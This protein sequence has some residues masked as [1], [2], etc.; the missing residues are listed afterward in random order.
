MAQQHGRLVELIARRVAQRLPASVEFEDLVQEGTLGLM[1]AIARFDPGR[2][3]AFQAYASRRI[4]GAILDSLRRGDWI[5]R[6][7]RARSKRV[8]QAEDILTQRLGRRP[9]A[10]ELSRF[11]S[12]ALRD[13]LRSQKDS[14]RSFVASLEALR[15]SEN[16]LLDE[17]IDLEA[18]V[19]QQ[20]LRN[21][22]LRTLQCEFSLLNHRERTLL[23]LYYA[24]GLSMREVGERLAV[25]EARVS[26]IHRR[27]LVQLREWLK[28][29][30][31][32]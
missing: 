11:T 28:L 2:G 1:D 19:E 16:S 5:T 4:R 30:R 29:Q 9:T 26:Q 31:V 14:A 20:V 21:W 6:G 25:S 17:I 12:L 10:D 8:S 22:D 18:D 13:V 23:S 15:E 7:S 24:E 3:V 27:C 32:S